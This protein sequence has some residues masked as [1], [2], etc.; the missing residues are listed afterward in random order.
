MRVGEGITV[1]GAGSDPGSGSRVRCLLLAYTSYSIVTTPPKVDEKTSALLNRLLI[2]YRPVAQSQEAQTDAQKGIARLDL[3]IATG[4][5][6]FFRLSFHDGGERHI[7]AQL[8]ENRSAGTYFWYRPFELAEFRGSPEDLAT[9]FCQELELLLTHE[10]RIVQRKGWLFW[11]FRCEY[12]V[13]EKWKSLSSHLAFRRGRFK[14]PRIEGRER[15]YKSG[16]IVRD[17]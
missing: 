6:Y 1:V 8:I 13:G 17:K 14:P 16:P 9:E 15:I 11:H 10:T 3:P 2:D 7:S 4:A 5:E 12:L